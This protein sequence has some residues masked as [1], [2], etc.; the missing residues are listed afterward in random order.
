MATTEYPVYLLSIQ[1][2]PVPFLR[3]SV[4]TAFP[5]KTMGYSRGKPFLYEFAGPETTLNKDDHRIFQLL[6]NWVKS[7]NV[8]HHGSHYELYEQYASNLLLEVLPTN[9][10][11][12]ASSEGKALTLGESRKA[13]VSWETGPTGKGKLQCR[14]SG[15]NL[16]ILP[17]TPLWYVDLSERCCGPIETEYEPKILLA[18][19]AMPDLT[20]QEFK[21][22]YTE[23]Q[24]K[25]AHATISAPI[26]HEPENWYTLVEENR[27]NRWFEFELG[28]IIDDEKINLLPCLIQIIQQHLSE[29]GVEMLSS[30]PPTQQLSIRLDNGKYLSIP[31]SRVQAI[32]KII[33]ELYDRESLSGHHRIQL[34]QLRAAQLI[35]L[36][37]ALSGVKMRWFGEEKIQELGRRLQHYQEVPDVKMPKNFNA[38]L[39][40]Y[41][42]RGVNW[43]QFL[44]ECQTAGILADDMGLGK[45]IQTLCHLLIEKQNDRMTA[46]VLIVVPT[47]MIASWQSEIERFT[48]SLTVLTLHGTH[49]KRKFDDIKNHDII[50]TTYPLL[51]RD[52]DILLGHHYYYI[53]LDEAQIIKNARAKVTRI[54]TAIQADHRLCLTGTPL[55]NHLEELWSIF[56]FLLPGLLGNR[57][58]FRRL[59]VVPIEKNQDANRRDNLKRRVAPFLLRRTKQQVLEEL[60]EKSEIV[61]YLDL[62]DAQ[63]DL[64]ESI[65]LTMDAKVISAIQQRGLARSQLIVL[66]ALLRLRQICCDPRLMK[67]EHAHRTDESVKIQWLVDTLPNLISEG[68]R[69]LL[70]SSF[71][72]MLQL[73]EPELNKLD[74]P[75]VKLV[76]QTKH[77][78]TV[79]ESFQNGDVPVFLISLKAGGL[80]LN[81]TTADTVIHFDPWWNPAAE[82]QATDRAHRIGQTKPIFVY[83]L[84]TRG[85]VEER[86]VE[87]Q[88]H[89][90]LLLD[91][92]FLKSMKTDQFLSKED[93]E[94]LL[95]PLGT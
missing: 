52:H 20:T 17:T 4:I 63:R 38:E 35:E 5:L 12:W 73:I 60:P 19:L 68:R 95:K 49:R 16:L 69:I 11:Y 32:L 56:N 94:Y 50:L 66:D 28:V 92:L 40:E 77:R 64:Y 13:N 46:P 89:K 86:I 72:S 53:I 76:G 84:I 1:R 31:V 27:K 24:N 26:I 37:K 78:A 48:P 62:A 14:V 51:I 45:T 81:L 9:R 70:F 10:A 79:I 71:A 15:R 91:E 21:K 61:T 67:L 59:F 47:S 75:Y 80:G 22:V 2:E 34:S 3:L 43:L 57:S 85:T 8:I 42:K 30:L 90:Q 44:R 41:Q 7:N 55:E 87:L 74:I 88:K 93:L 83:K 33:T 82:K 39:R 23:L 29:D 54:A 18:L 58:Q 36:E 6:G 65:R 25:D